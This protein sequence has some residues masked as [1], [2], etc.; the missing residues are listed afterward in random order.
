MHPKQALREDN[1]PSLKLP[2]EDT[3]SKK[4]GKEFLGEARKQFQ[5]VKD[6]EIDDAVNKVGRSILAANGEDPQ[7]FHFLV[8]KDSVPNAFAVPGGYIFVFTGLL[9]RVSS[10]DELAGV[11]SHEIGHVK[12]DHFFKEDKTATFASIAGIVAALLT[13]EPGV[14]IAGAMTAE[15]ARLSFSRE[16]EREADSVG[17]RM[18]NR[19]GYDP[20]GLYHFFKTLQ[21]YEQYNP[22]LVP[23]YFSTHPAVEER[24][25]TL[26]MLARRLPKISDPPPRVKLD[27][28]RIR[29]LVEIEDHPDKPFTGFA[30]DPL[31]KGISEER[32]HY[33]TGLSFLKNNQAQKA[34]SEFQKAIETNP[35]QSYY[36]SGLAYAYFMQELMDPAKA[37]AIKSAMMDPANGEG[38][39]VLGYIAESEGDKTAALAHYEKARSLRPGDPMIYF[40]LGSLYTSMGNKKEA[41]WNLALYY[42]YEM[43]TEEALKELQKARETFADDHSYRTRVEGEMLDILHEGL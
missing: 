18:L 38:D 11:L 3:R 41:A 17:L 31:A 28:G 6:P 35:D 20:E 33:F 22:S 27:W 23:A 10:V 39:M 29:A 1:L 21:A 9:S 14:A 13:R 37:E 30:L 5:F 2:E 40:K 42:R 36:H 34:V 25:V 7:S 12:K 32:L 19:A 24:E 26:Q 8:V 15:S 43:Q 4:L 16:N